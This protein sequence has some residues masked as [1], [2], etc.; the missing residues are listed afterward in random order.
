MSENIM[1]LIDL[2]KACFKNLQTLKKIKNTN[3]IS[4]QIETAKTSLLDA[5]SILNKKISENS[6][7]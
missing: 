7:I 6:E 1:T 5:I 2:Q 3:A 4:Q